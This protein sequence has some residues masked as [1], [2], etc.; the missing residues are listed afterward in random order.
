MFWTTP[1]G[2]LLLKVDTCDGDQ[3]NL[4]LAFGNNHNRRA[5]EISTILPILDFY[6]FSNFLY[7][8]NGCVYWSGWNLK[9]SPW[10]LRCAVKKGNLD[11]YEIKL[12]NKTFSGVSSR[13]RR[14]QSLLNLI[15]ARILSLLPRP[16]RLCSFVTSLIHSSKPSTWLLTAIGRKLNCCGFVAKTRKHTGRK[17]IDS[18]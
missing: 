13:N 9:G 16:F 12:K 6:W 4:C 3:R 14:N 8:I 5:T 18:A 17:E 2:I 1:P 7:L 11:V 10:S 15:L